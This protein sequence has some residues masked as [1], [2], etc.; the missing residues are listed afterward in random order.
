MGVQGMQGGMAAAEPSDIA[1]DRLAGWAGIGTAI[2][3]AAYAVSFVVLKNNELSALFLLIGPFLSTLVL[4]ALYNRF[5]TVN[6][7]LSLWFLLL[8][9][10]GAIGAGVH[11]GFDLANQ[12]HP[13]ATTSDLPNSIDPRGLLTFGASGMAL[14]AAAWLA[15]RT[16]GLPTWVE[17]VAAVLGV[18]LVVTYLARLIVLDANSPAVLLPALVAGVMSP[19]VYLGLGL[20]LI[21]GVM[22]GAS[23]TIRR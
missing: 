9:T 17:P 5:R 10:V 16:I 7:G 15:G 11:G 1:F 6:S 4:V 13:P 19:L 2:A 22:P 3:G 12:L 20:W 23:A 18:V 21:R 14:L 8:A